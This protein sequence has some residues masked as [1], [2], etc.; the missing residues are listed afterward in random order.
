[1]ELKNFKICKTCLTPKEMEL[2]A[3]KRTNKETGKIYYK[4]VCKVCDNIRCRERKR[5]TEKEINRHKEYYQKNKDKFITYTRKS[6]LKTKYKLTTEDFENM[7]LTQ[8]NKCLIC[9]LVKPLVID[10]CHVKGHTRGLLCNSCNLGIGHLR[11]NIDNLK[12]A[13]E[14][15]EIYG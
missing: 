6:L 11:D 13:I 14:Y 9:K 8:N 10:H 2:M 1:M 15:L 3:V 7:K 12:S 5:G 4:A